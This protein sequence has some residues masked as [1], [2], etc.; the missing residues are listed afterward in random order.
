ML[1]SSSMSVLANPVWYVKTNDENG[2]HRAKHVAVASL[3]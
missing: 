1:P 3:I 2:L